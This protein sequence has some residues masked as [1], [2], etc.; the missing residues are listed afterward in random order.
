MR[1]TH[2][3]GIDFSPLKLRALLIDLN[4]TLHVGSKP[5]PGAV[6]AL[7]RLRAAKIPFVFWYVERLEQLSSNEEDA[8]AQTSSNS[9]K[10]STASLLGNLQT[11][12]FE[13]EERELLTSLGACR[14]LVDQRGLK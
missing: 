9:T 3:S 5:T 14:A 6:D 8:D 12:G 13:A 7:K 4:G 11:M 2:G 10:E 1:R